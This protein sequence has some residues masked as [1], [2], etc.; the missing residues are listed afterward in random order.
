MKVVF[1]PE[2]L[3]ARA[4]HAVGILAEEPSAK[5]LTLVDVIEAMRRGE[6]I[7]MRPATQSEIKRAEAYI[8]MFEIGAMLAEKMHTLLD[9][10]PLETA[11]AKVAAMGQLLGSGGIDFPG[12]LDI[13]KEVG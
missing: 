5:W 9:Q 1:F 7:A 12:I 10:E 2:E 4:P 3:N 8:A 11:T 6:T 13:A